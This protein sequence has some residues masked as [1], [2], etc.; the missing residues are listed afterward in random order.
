MS[1]NV[2]VDVCPY[3]GLRRV[4]KSRFALA[5][6]G[7]SM[8]VVALTGHGKTSRALSVG[9]V[10]HDG[11]VCFSTLKPD[12]MEKTAPHRFGP[13]QVVDLRKDPDYKYPEGVEPVDFD[14]VVFVRS[15]LD[16]SRCAQTMLSLVGMGFGGNGKQSGD[17]STWMKQA[18][19]PLAGFLWAASKLGGRGGIGWVVAAIR[20]TVLAEG[21][22]PEATPSWALAQTLC[23]DM[24]EFAQALSSVSAMDDRLRDS[25]LIG[26][27]SSVAPFTT[28]LLKRRISKRPSRTFKPEFFD[29][30]TATLYVISPDEGST[31]LVAGMLFDTLIEMWKEKTEKG[32]DP[33]VLAIFADEGATSAPIPNLAK[34]VNTVRGY[35]VIL[36]VAIQNTGQLI[37]AYGENEGLSARK[38][39]PVYLLMYGADERE[40]YEE[41]AASSAKTEI[42][43]ASVHRATGDATLTGQRDR[44]VDWGELRP[45]HPDQARLVVNRSLGELVYLPY[46]EDFLVLREAGIE[47]FTSTEKTLTVSPWKLWWQ[48]AA[49]AAASAA[50]LVWTAATGVIAPLAATAFA[51]LGIASPWLAAGGEVSGP[52]VSAI[53]WCP[54][55]GKQAD[56]VVYRPDGK[57]N[58]Q[59]FQYCLAGDQAWFAQTLA[60]I[61]HPDRHPDRRA[62]WVDE[63][64][65][66]SP[67]ST[68]IVLTATLAP[69]NAPDG[70]LPVSSTTRPE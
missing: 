26:M 19:D 67:G 41:L 36:V 70:A 69:K 12:G 43:S 51:Q 21:D 27:T 54:D 24:P 8:L 65:M 48:G 3:G 39:F 49:V 63:R 1:K 6:T 18:E 52:T 57:G 60:A 56:V 29:H 23:D 31:G 38:G 61:G 17:N 13:K 40:I 20:K 22:D 28:Q 32:L 4:R 35:R 16:A 9:C 15:P 62:I 59:P 53:R 45:Q 30:P 47:P 66:P 50:L 10:D 2:G 34:R 68:D 55:E 37:D 14:P 44:L 7:P 46:V 58:L 5:K 25:V 33:E 64:P 11:P 42:R